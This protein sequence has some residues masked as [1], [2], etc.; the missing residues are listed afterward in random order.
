MK[1]ANR[2]LTAALTA[3]ALLAVAAPVR[4]VA[5]A[6][7]DSCLLSSGTWVNSPLPQEQNGGFRITFEATPSSNTVDAV[8]GLSSGPASSFANLAAIVRFNSNGT[9][10][11]RD[12]ST[13]TAASPIRYNGGATYRFIL[14]VHVSLQ[15]YNAYVMVGT[16]QKTIGRNLAFRTEQSKVLTLGYVSAMTDPGTHEICNIAVRNW[17]AAPAILTQ[18]TNRTVT[19]GQIASFSVASTGT[20]PLMYQWKRGGAAIIGA[21]SS[22]YSTAVTTSA[23]NGAQFSVTVS[24]GA[25]TATSNAAT[26]TVT[27]AAV[28]PSITSQPVSQ[29]L[30][31]G[32]SAT[33]AVAT[34][35]T[36]P[37]TYQWSK[38]GAA[39]SGAVSSI[40]TTPATSVSDN[41]TQFNVLVSNSMGSARSNAAI[42]NVKAAVIA[43]SI[44]AQPIGR[45]V[46]A[47][48]TATFSVAASGTATLTYQWNKNG[49]AIS[50]ATSTS[51]TTP[52][53]SSSDNGAQFSVTVSNTAGTINSSAASLTVSAASV[54]LNSSVN[55]LSFGNVDVSTSSTQ[56][57][58]L[59][60]A[61]N[62]NV[63]ISQV[64]VA[65]A[66]FNSTGANGIT[67][68]PGQSTSLTATFAPSASG[69]ASGTITVSSNAT[70]SPSSVALSGTGMAPKTHAVVLNWDADASGTTGYNCYLSMVPGGPYQK[71]NS[72]PVTGTIYTE[73]NV[74]SG[75]TYYYVVTAVN[76][77]NQESGYSSEVSAIVP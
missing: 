65:G 9:I 1:N 17:S 56:N 66:G 4:T 46:T 68:S 51:Y 5:A 50:G 21:N 59:T 73:S 39:I 18:P 20:A 64:M 58:T 30:T 8:T 37:M 29:N 52:A 38:N 60:N 55:S 71:V 31:T 16:R 45:T 23:D 32:Q 53:T 28:A 62:A 11:A 77:S 15:T 35:G 67:L 19:A 40:Y 69:A 13:Y 7:P 34:T 10:D 70:N 48:Q 36:A 25:G 41:G 27:S 6:N 49:A 26:L 14:D 54:L 24:N 76:A 3:W 33:F 74:Q 43:P 61:G 42:L 63:T 22:N 72:S 44:T 75:S 47:G 12:G 57:V 2:I